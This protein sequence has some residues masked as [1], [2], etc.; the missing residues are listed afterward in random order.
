[1]LWIITTSKLQRT[2]D[3]LNTLFMFQAANH[4]YCPNRLVKESLGVSLCW[5][6]KLARGSLAKKAGAL[7]EHSGQGA[8]RDCAS[9]PWG[10]PW[11][12]SLP[13][14]FLPS[15]ALLCEGS[16]QSNSRAAQPFLARYW[17]SEPKSSYSNCFSSAL[18]RFLI[19]LLECLYLFFL[20]LWK[21]KCTNSKCEV[22]FYSLV[23]NSKN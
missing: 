11:L 3:F 15:R 13:R 18:H 17:A 7:A 6:I 19:L 20:N 9:A 5:W 21:E 2:S 23:V 10:E 14:P 4:L 16:R 22:S 12:L 8:P 1:M